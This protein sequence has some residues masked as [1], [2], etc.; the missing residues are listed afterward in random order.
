V[1]VD[2][3]T[4]S[5]GGSP[6]FYRSASSEGPPPL[7]LHGVPTS[8]DDWTAL[9]ERTGGI[10]PDLIGFGRSG[11]GGHLEYSLPGL[12][13]FLEA[14]LGEIAVDMV[15]L[16]VNDWGAGPG[17][18]FAQRHPERIERLVLVNALPLLPGY[19]WHRIAR[20]WRRPL[21]GEL[22][23]G[24]TTRW[25]LARGLRGGSGNP[26]IWTASRLASV[27]QQFDQGTQRAILRLYRSADEASLAAAG[28]DLHRVTAPALVIHGEL[29]PWIP[30]RVADEYAAALPNATLER[31]PNAGHWPWL[32]DEGIA[33]RIAEFLAERR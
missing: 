22:A 19:S 12:T 30:A 8:S 11:K 13:E 5:L 16:V 3:H 29:D 2:E 33:E 24:S 25:I 4:I 10:A 15:K 26:D 31:V 21:L 14:F 32:E 18:A 6:V 20:L 17:L 23:M 7:Y 27:W 1:R 28:R 9:L